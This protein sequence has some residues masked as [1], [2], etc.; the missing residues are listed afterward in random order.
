MPCRSATSWPAGRY[1]RPSRRPRP[2]RRRTGAT[3]PA[4]PLRPPNQPR[5][6]ERG[7]SVT[8]YNRGALAPLFMSVLHDG[9]HR[10]LLS[11]PRIV[12]VVNVTQDSF[13]DGGQIHDTQAENA[14]ALKLSEHCADILV[15]GCESS[16][17]GAT[18]VP[19]DEEFGLVVTVI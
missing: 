16:R 2:N 17:P 12:G 5:K 11:R 3:N 4:R 6:P 8:H 10:L 9:S 14:H 13:S 19:V 1:V 18:A 15:F 7:H